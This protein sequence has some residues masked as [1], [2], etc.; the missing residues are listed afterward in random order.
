MGLIQFFYQIPVPELKNRK[1]LKKF[2]ISLSDMENKHIRELAVIFCT[3]EYLI[4]INR[5][6]LK[7]NFYTDIITF[8]YSL[9]NA[10]RGEIYISVERVRDNAMLHKTSRIEEIHRVLFHGLLHLCGYKDKLKQD[11]LKMTAK[12]DF[13]L[14]RYFS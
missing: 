9:K 3:D 13:Y 11:K 7:H 1:K 6:H 5:A 8:D 12:E 2:L 4:E 14:A 10:I